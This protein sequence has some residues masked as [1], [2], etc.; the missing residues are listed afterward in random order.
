MALLHSVLL[1]NF[2]NTQKIYTLAGTNEMSD[3]RSFKIA[4][5]LVYAATAIIPPPRVAFL[6]R[7]GNLP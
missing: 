5:Y 7:L 1:F 4:V 2:P 6:P 3:T